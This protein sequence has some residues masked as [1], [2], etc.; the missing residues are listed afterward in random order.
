LSPEFL[1]LLAPTTGDQAARSKE[2]AQI[3]LAEVTAEAIS[4]CMADAGFAEFATLPVLLARDRNTPHSEFVSPTKL[5]R[6]GLVSVADPALE[7]VPEQ[8]QIEMH[9]CIG[10]G[11][12]APTVADRVNQF[13]V[14]RDSTANPFSN[15]P[16]L[17]RAQ[18]A[19]IALA[20]T[21]EFNDYR[22]CFRRLGVPADVASNPTD[23]LN[24]L[25]G[26]MNQRLTVLAPEAVQ[27]WRDGAGVL[28]AD[29]GLLA[30]EASAC[31]RTF[32]SHLTPRL[33]EMRRS[34]VDTQREQLLLGQQQFYDAIGAVDY[35]PDDH[36][37]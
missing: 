30:R 25:I 17:V 21:T 24:W 13:V 10:E 33:E 36:P 35:S 8:A 22:E 37:L 20:D 26:E 28:D 32:E 4:D 15:W 18:A 27:R 11:G 7:G 6:H 14:F 9:D 12:T 29:E 16:G 1:D 5:E 34:I 3:L 19:E 31:F 2:S 23:A